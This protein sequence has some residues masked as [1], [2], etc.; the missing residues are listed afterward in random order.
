MFPPL[1]KMF[2][3]TLIVVIFMATMTSFLRRIN[4]HDYGMAMTPYTKM[5]EGVLSQMSFHEARFSH[6]YD[7]RFA[8]DRL[9]YDERKTALNLIVQAYLAKMNGFGIG[10]WL[11][12]GSLIG[13][14]WNG[15]ILRDDN[16]DVMVSEESVYYLT[17]PST[18][19]PVTPTVDRTDH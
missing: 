5:T 11:M 18:I 13:R 10:S 2:R 17:L 14:Y 15:K 12:H 4:G 1:L 9:P 6:H 3:A 16:I 7:A 19:T 8:V